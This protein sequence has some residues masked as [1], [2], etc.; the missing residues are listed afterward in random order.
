MS[1]KITGKPLKVTDFP[2]GMRR[3]P[4]PPASVQPE[5]ASEGNA[6][7]IP[8]GPDPFRE[9]GRYNPR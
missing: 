1:E 2:S 3:G 4:T 5:S 7:S 6:T 9:S 8:S